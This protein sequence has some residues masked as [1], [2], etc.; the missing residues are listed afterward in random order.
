MKIL[1][2]GNS[3]S[4]DAQRYL[5]RLAKHDGVELKTVNLYIGGCSLR[6]HYLN[7]LDDIDAY[8]FEFNGEKTGIKVSI[9]EALASDN[10]DFVTLQQASTLS[11]KYETYSPYIEALAEFVRK[12]CPHSKIL[13][14]QTWAYENESDRL[15]A[16]SVYANSDEMLA[17]ICDSYSMAAKAI[18]ADG[19]IPCGMAMMKATKMGIGKMHRDTFHA[20]LG[21]GRYLLALCWYKKFTGRDISNNSFNDFDV[22]VSDFER[23]TVIAA[24]NSVMMQGDN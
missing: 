17:A 7:M 3:F 15:K 4:H 1:S 24:V 6:T 8:D 11:G 10:W 22:P 21:A 14:H 20:S 2:I 19:I 13:I 5:H 9:R 18:S 23:E 12:Y 16:L